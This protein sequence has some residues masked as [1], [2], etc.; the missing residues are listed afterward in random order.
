MGAGIFMQMTIT[1]SR[2]RLSLLPGRGYL[3]SRSAY[4]SILRTVQIH[5]SKRPKRKSRNLLEIAAYP[6]E[7]TSL[8]A[9]LCFW[10]SVHSLFCS[11]T[12][13]HERF[14]ILCQR[15]AQDHSFF[16]G[17]SAVHFTD[18]QLSLFSI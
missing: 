9:R 15:P 2:R 13:L 7:P 3:R 1:P 10:R 5:S 17:G 18:Y 14:N 12:S 11:S 4:E 6:L 8:W 16:V